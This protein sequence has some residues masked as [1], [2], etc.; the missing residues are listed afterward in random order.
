VRKLKYRLKQERAIFIL[1]F[2]LKLN[3]KF[4]LK[5]VQNF[6]NWKCVEF[7]KNLEKNRVDKFSPTASNY[8]LQWKLM[9]TT[10]QLFAIMQIL[11][12]IH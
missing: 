1:N 4:P 10:T 11:I 12:K 7:R 8:L 9:K 2:K 5:I 3:S 6:K